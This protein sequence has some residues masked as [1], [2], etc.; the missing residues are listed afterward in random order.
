MTISGI[1][2]I[3]FDEKQALI[4]AS[5]YP[6]T[7]ALGLACIALALERHYPV[8]TCDKIWGKIDLN[9]KFIIAK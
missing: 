6:Q 7:K 5:I 8:L 9:I 1:K 4:A 2:I 3:N